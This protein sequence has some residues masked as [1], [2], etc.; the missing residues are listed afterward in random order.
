MVG[1]CLGDEDVGE[2]LHK[3]PLAVQELK[4]RHRKPLQ[5]IRPETIEGHQQQWWR[6]LLSCGF[7]SG[8]DYAAGQ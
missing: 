6:A 8:Q 7:F 3:D 4:V 2:L 1:K 5:V